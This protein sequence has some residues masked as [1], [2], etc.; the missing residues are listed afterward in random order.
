MQG[1]RDD[2]N[3]NIFVIMHSNL[4]HRSQDVQGGEALRAAVVYLLLEVLVKLKAGQDDTVLPLAGPPAQQLDDLERPLQ[5]L[6]CLHPLHTRTL[7]L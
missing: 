6:P 3:N 4:A 7:S 1:L 5:T 2:N